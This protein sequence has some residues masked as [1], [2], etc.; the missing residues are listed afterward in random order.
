MNVFTWVWALAFCSDYQWWLT[1]EQHLTLAHR[2]CSRK[3]A[4]NYNTAFP[5]LSP[6]TAAKVGEIY[7][8]CLR[9]GSGGRS[10]APLQFADANTSGGS[11]PFGGA[12][13][14]CLPC[15]IKIFNHRTIDWE[16]GKKKEQGMQS[17]LECHWKRKNFLWHLR[18]GFGLGGFSLFV[19][20]VWFLSWHSIAVT[21]PAVIHTKDILT[22]STALPRLSNLKNNT[23]GSVTH[24]KFIPGFRK[25]LHTA[26]FSHCTRNCYS[27]FEW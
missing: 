1:S 2:V 5:P 15:A 19:L 24:W 17:P 6:Y 16:E 9:T 20:G 22:A 3:E 21:Y 8:S 7:S 26:V 13:A 18:F 11:I 23:L 25:H 27:G 4:P 10:R 14:F 12:L